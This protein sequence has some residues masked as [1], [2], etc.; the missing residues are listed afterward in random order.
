MESA[1]TPTSEPARLDSSP[2]TA[3]SVQSTPPARASNQRR[4]PTQVPAKKKER[5]GEGILLCPIKGRREPEESKDPCGAAT[6]LQTVARL[7]HPLH[8][9][10]SFKICLPPW[11]EAEALR[12]WQCHPRWS[13]FRPLR[14]YCSFQ[15]RLPR[16]ARCPLRAVNLSSSHHQCGTA[17]RCRGCPSS[18]CLSSAASPQ[19]RVSLPVRVPGIILQTLGS[20][21]WDPSTNRWVSSA[22][23]WSHIASPWSPGTGL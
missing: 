3:A 13:S 5:L 19:I 18:A 15:C 11:E 17:L 20:V 16:P 2:S 7:Q 8:C 22:D 4:F 1:L 12:T 10:A 9:E 21:P 6:P 14:T 23:L